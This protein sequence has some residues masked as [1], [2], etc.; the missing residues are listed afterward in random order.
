MAYKIFKP[1]FSKL[2][3]VEPG[4]EYL[5]NIFFKTPSLEELKKYVLPVNGSCARKTALG[6]VVFNKPY[7][8]KAGDPFEFE[9][10]LTGI[11]AIGPGPCNEYVEVEIAEGVYFYSRI[12]DGFC[13]FLEIVG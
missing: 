11:V 5:L 10:T 8:F 9:G 1:E 2:V 13:L 6:S 4:K 3:E 7:R 12:L